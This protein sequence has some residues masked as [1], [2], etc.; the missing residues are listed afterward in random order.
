MACLVHS[1]QRDELAEANHYQ[2]ASDEM[3]HKEM[4]PG[5]QVGSRAFAAWYL[6]RLLK[7]RKRRLGLQTKKVITWNQGPD[8]RA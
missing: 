8:V 5:S 6:A 2:L 7:R 4:E 3:K 1:H